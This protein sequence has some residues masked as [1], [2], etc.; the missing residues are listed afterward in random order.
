MIIR[1]RG[2]KIE[3][4]EDLREYQQLRRELDG[5]QDS[6]DFPYPVFRLTVPQYAK[7]LKDL[8]DPYHPTTLS[9]AVHN[10]WDEFT[11]GYMMQEFLAKDRVKKTIR[12][13]GAAG[14]GDERELRRQAQRKL[15][16][17]GRRGWITKI[18][19][20]QDMY[21]EDWI[22]TEEDT[23]QLRKTLWWTREEMIEA[24]MNPDDDG[25]FEL[26]DLGR[27]PGRV[28]AGN[29]GREGLGNS[30]LVSRMSTCMNALL[31]DFAAR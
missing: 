19:Q 2:L 1:R 5:I 11:G 29:R 12:E 25:L 21:A 3:Y 18:H 23:N 17:R 16:V 8:K 7:L 30:E 24:D 31:T 22:M 4:P 13:S 10:L 27:D 15:V 28:R 26:K 20:K 14:S 6:P 9:L